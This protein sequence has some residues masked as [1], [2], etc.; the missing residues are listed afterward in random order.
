MVGLWKQLGR[1][2]TCKRGK[3]GPGG[4]VER[5]RSESEVSDFLKKKQPPK[6]SY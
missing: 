5:W 6:K 2:C 1:I 4:G 3:G